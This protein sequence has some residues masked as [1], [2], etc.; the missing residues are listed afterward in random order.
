MQTKDT[1]ETSSYSTPLGTFLLQAVNLYCKEFQ[2]LKSETIKG[3]EPVPSGKMRICINLL[4]DVHVK[5]RKISKE[6]ITRLGAIVGLKRKNE[7]EEV[8]DER[9]EKNCVTACENGGVT[10]VSFLITLI[11]I[12]SYK[13]I[14]SFSFLQ[15][16]NALKR[17]RMKQKQLLFSRPCLKDAVK[18][19]RG[20]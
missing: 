10:F 16:Q 3:T 15:R 13:S 4:S 12:T 6:T 5:A 17:S 14:L 2:F 18:N 1:L 9:K 8:C 7:D 20:W 11:F 19:S